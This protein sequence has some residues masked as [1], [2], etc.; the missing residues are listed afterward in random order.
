[1]GDVGTPPWILEEKHE[2]MG[3]D[4]FTGRMVRR[5]ELYLQAR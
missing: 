4:G 5:R 2:I 3:K 1:M